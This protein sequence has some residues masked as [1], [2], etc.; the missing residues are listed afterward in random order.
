MDKN[1]LEKVML[2]ERPYALQAIQLQV[3]QDI[4]SLLETLNERIEDMK[5]ECLHP[6]E[7][8]VDERGK[9]LERSE[10]P[11]MPWI[12][13]TLFNEGPNP[14]Y[15]VI[16]DFYRKVPLMP[17]EPLTVDF[18]SHKIMK[19]FLFCNPKQKAKVR[20]YAVS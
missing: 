15:V 12:S 13:F 9:T 7:L 14:V 20:L 4:A 16:N 6:I 11:T 17:E 2:E 1:K 5:A 19:V 3:L 8:E 18:R 10:Y